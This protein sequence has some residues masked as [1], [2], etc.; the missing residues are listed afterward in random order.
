M[1][2]ERKASR[3]NV[4]VTG[5]GTLH[6]KDMTTRKIADQR[7]AYADC[8]YEGPLAMFLSRSGIDQF[9]IR[10]RDWLMTMNCLIHQCM[11]YLSHALLEPRRNKRHNWADIE[12]HQCVSPK[13]YA[14]WWSS[15]EVQDT[16]SVPC[17][18]WR[19]LMT[20]WIN[21]R[22]SSLDFWTVLNRGSELS[23]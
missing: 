12:V 20:C 1:I 8:Q 15:F 11:Q 18:L 14:L 2:C 3:S 13:E 4:I 5:G 6:L 9:N 19:E 7:N 21:Y 17:C 22:D 10:Y 23:F 16:L